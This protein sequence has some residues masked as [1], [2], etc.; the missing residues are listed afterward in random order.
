MILLF[1]WFAFVFCLF[2]FCINTDYRTTIAQLVML[3]LLYLY[4]LW[5]EWRRQ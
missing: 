5:H 4:A 2:A 1:L 3:E